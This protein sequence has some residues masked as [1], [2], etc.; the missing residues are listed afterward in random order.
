MVMYQQCTLR[1]AY[2]SLLEAPLD[3][4]ALVLSLYSQVANP[5]LLVGFLKQAK[6]RVSH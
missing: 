2:H 4:E 1:V 5:A 6:K 3:L